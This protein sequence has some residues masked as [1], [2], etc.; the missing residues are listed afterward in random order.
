MHVTLVPWGVDDIEML[1]RANTPELTRYLGGPE[2]EDALAERHA[3][4]LGGGAR[5]F[6]VEVDGAAAGYAGWWDEEHAG[7]PAYEIGCVVEPGWQG[8]GVA[9]AALGEVVRLAAATG[10]R[11]LIVGYS[12][13][14]NAASSALCRRVGFSLAGT[15]AFPAEDGGDPVPVNVWLIHT[16]AGPMV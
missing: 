5:M 12:N 15:A 8:R 14:A 7:E 4:Y 1:R 16:S 6:R 9:S 10:D 3:E 11:R 13:P 2:A